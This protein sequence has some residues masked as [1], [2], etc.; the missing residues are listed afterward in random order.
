MQVSVSE[1]D[2]EDGIW[3]MPGMKTFKKPKEEQ[4]KKEDEKASQATTSK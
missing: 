1:K 3:G 2:E 4:K